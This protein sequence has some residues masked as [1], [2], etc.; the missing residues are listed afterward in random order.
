[1]KKVFAYKGTRM[2]EYPGSHSWDYFQENESPCRG[3]RAMY[4]LFYNT[5]Y[6]EPY[7]VHK[8]H[9][10]FFVV[11]GKGKMIIGSE[12][13]ELEPGVSMVAPANIPHAIR[14]TSEKDLEIY[15]YH[16]PAI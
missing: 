7:G 15:L 11:G 8:D 6:I 3:Y 13:F 5:E 1:M 12:E 4:N 2:S 10:G 14:K 16:F 9:E